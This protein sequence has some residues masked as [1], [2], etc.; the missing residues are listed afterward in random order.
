M[1][2]EVRR[3]DKSIE[4]KTKKFERKMLERPNCD[5]RRILSVII[6][7]SPSFENNDV[8]LQLFCFDF[9]S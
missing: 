9:Q 7:P 6:K 8:L 5:L 1:I 2:T 4:R 3:E